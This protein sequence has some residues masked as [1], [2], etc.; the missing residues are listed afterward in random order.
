[1]AAHEHG[2]AVPEKALGGNAA[3][4]QCRSP[5]HVDGAYNLQCA[6][7]EGSADDGSI[8]EGAVAGFLYDLLDAPDWPDSP[9]NTADGDDDPVTFPGSYLADLVKT[10]NVF[11]R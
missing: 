5:H 9:Y 7:S 10:C 8:I 3:T 11:P 4:G 1:M 2:H 6:Y